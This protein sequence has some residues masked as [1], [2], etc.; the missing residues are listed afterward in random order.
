MKNQDCRSVNKIHYI[1]PVSLL[2][3]LFGITPVA[4]SQIEE[5]VVTATKR[6]D[7]LIQDIPLSVQAISGDSLQEAGALD[8]NDF[9][10]QVPGLSAVDQGPGD[11]RY[12]IRGINSA[13]AG[14]VGLYFDEIV[15]TGNMLTAA[16]G[17][18]IDVRL[19]DMDR[20]EVLKGPQGT[21]FGSSSLSGAIRWIPAYPDMSQASMDVGAGFSSTRHSDGLG[22]TVDAMVNIPIVKDRVALRFAGIKIDNDGYIDDQWR[23]D[24][25]DDDT[26]ALRGILAVQ[27]TDNLKFSVLGMHQD[28]RTNARA[29]WMDQLIDLP[30][31]PTLNGGPTPTKYYNTDMSDASFDD[32]TDMY[33]VKF[34]YDPEWGNVIFTSSMCSGIHTPDGTLA[35]DRLYTAVFSCDGT[36]RSFIVQA[37]DAKYYPMKSPCFQLAARSRC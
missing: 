13:G 12:N 32:E 19:F 27:V 31:S 37:P 8:F 1:L 15:V 20:I 35:R 29:G 5:I 28:A 34:E 16:G 11:K 21:T 22:Y 6:G 25:N 33:N 9:F 23:K 14:T 24:G 17:R 10:R 3:L 36:G 30:V 4:Q 18:S 26:E 2:I 7:T